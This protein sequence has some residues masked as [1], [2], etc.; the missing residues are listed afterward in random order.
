MK[1][2]I[3][4]VIFRMCFKKFSIYQCKN[5]FRPTLVLVGKPDISS[6]QNQLMDFRGSLRNT[7]LA[8]IFKDGH[9][10]LTKMNG[11]RNY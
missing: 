5:T 11:V 9:H 1:N 7:L 3:F 2:V 10:I 6:V 4:Y 8:A